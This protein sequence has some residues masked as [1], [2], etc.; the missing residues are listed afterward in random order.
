[1]APGVSS[2]FTIIE[3]MVVVG[4][5]IILA[6]LVTGAARRLQASTRQTKCASNLRQMVTVAIAYADEHKGEFPWAL[7]RESGYDSWCWDFVVPSGGKPEP[8]VMWNGCGLNQIMQCPS[9]LQGRAN[10]ENNPFTGYNY[11][12]SF[13]GK[14]HGD[15]GDRERPARLSHIKNPGQT[16]LFGDGH[17]N[18]G[19]NKF[20][21][22]PKF[23]RYFDDSGSNLR[24]AGTQGFRHSGKT[25][26]AFADG[27]VEALEKSYDIA[28][29][30]AFVSISTEGVK[31][32]FISEDNRLYD[33]N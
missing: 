16:A 17:Y 11:N 23:D 18:G 7:R 2:A 8:G 13:I 5:V 27:H 22:A 6:T 12:T 10:W 32:G 33:L 31:C 26:I 1:M 15:P 24:K 4:I 14:A 28:G 29:N 19:A 3:L 20:M 9:Y 30:S 25:N 21:R